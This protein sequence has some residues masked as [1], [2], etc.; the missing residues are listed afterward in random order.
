MSIF[1]AIHCAIFGEVPRL[2]GLQA[3]EDPDAYINNRFHPGDAFVAMTFV[4]DDGTPS[5][6]I[7]VHRTVAGVR[8]ATSATRHPDPEAFLR[9]LRK[10][11]VLVDY[12]KFARFIEDTALVR[13]RS[14]A[15]LV[16]L[17][18]YSSLRRALEPLM[19]PRA[20]DRR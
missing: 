10:D 8:T 15:A 12:C 16:G 14:F 9:S 4:A 6:E 20:I 5:V 3:S 7:A 19:P 13:G 2:A 11:F 18:R 17:S 1:E